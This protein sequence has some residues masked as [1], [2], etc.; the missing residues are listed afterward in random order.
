M[1]KLEKIL[2]I[3]ALIIAVPGI[4]LLCRSRVRAPEDIEGWG[5]FATGAFGIILIGIALLLA[6]SGGAIIL[7]RICLSRKRKEKNNNEYKH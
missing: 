2:F 6:A 7:D 4:Y 3:L 5:Q 1:K